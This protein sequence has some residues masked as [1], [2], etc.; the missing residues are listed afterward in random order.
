MGIYD[1]RNVHNN[2]LRLY[3]ILNIKNTRAQSAQLETKR[4]Y[5]NTFKY[6]LLYI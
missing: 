3:K 2:K 4:L 1:I 6:I 5:K